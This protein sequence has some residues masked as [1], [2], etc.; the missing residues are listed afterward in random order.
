VV[1]ALIDC[2]TDMNPTRMKKMFAIAEQT[3][4]VIVSESRMGSKA[5]VFIERITKQKNEK[6][7]DAVMKLTDMA[8]SPDLDLMEF[9]ALDKAC[10]AMYTEYKDIK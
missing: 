7:Y 10:Q 6:L 4:E 3:G 5:I 1:F 8:K 9:K 2:L